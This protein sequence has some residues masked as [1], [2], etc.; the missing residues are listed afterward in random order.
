MLYLSI[1]SSAL[2]PSLFSVSGA[3]VSGGATS[4]L[5]NVVVDG[6]IVTSRGPAMALEFSL[7]IVSQLF[8]EEKCQELSK[9]L[10][11]KVR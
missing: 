1:F 9:Q 2:P 6:N 11:F 5:G 7:E 3:L 10:L 4:S 8:G